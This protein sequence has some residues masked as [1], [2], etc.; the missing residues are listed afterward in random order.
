MRIEGLHIEGFGPF[1]SKTVGPFTGSITV[2]HGA[3]AAGKSTLLAF[4]RMVLFGFPRQ[5]NT[6]YPPLAGG[7]HGGRLRL[8]DDAGN[9]YVVERFR[10]ARGGPVSIIS[11][12][13]APVDEAHLS[14]L[15]GGASS[16][17]FKN[18]FA[19][20]LDELQAE[21]SLRAADVDSQIY[22]AG[23]GA[24]RLP[25][26]IKAIRDKKNAIFR[27]QGRNT[28]ADLIVELEKVGDSLSAAEGNAA[29]YGGFVARLSD[30]GIQL[31]SLNAER[32]RLQ[33]QSGEI[34]RLNQGWGDWVSLVNVES[35]LEA[36]PH[37]DGFPEGGIAR[38]ENNEDQ[39][40]RA[41]QELDETKERSQLVEE[42][43][44]AE[45]ADEILLDRRDVI[46]HIRRGR[47]RFDDSVRDLPERKAE[48]QNLESSLDERLRDISPEWDE[49]R[50]ESFDTSIVTRDHIEQVRQVLAGEVIELRQRTARL[51]QAKGD[52]QELEEAENQARRNL[53]EKEEPTLDAAALEQRRSALR[54]T[55][56]RFEEFA[57]LRLRHSDL[58]DQMESITSQATVSSESP[59]IQSR[60]LPLLLSIVAVALVAISATLG[61][62]SLTIGG[63]AGAVLLIIAL[64][65]YLNANR[66]HQGGNSNENQA[67]L[68]SISKAKEEE[69]DAELKL[70]QVAAVLDLDLPDAVALDNVESGLGASDMALRAWEIVQQRLLNAAEA[71]KQQERRVEN[72]IQAHGVAQKGLEAA[73]AEWQTW[74]TE[75]DLAETLTPETMVEFRGR[76]ETARVALGEVRTMRLRVE[77]IETDIAEYLELVVPLADMLGMPINAEDP[78]QLASTADILIERYDVV[79]ESVNR[80]D[81]AR[82]EAEVISQQFRQREQRLAQH[83]DELAKLLITGGTDDPEEFRSRAAQHAERYDMEQKRGDHLVRLQQFSGPGEQFDH[84]KE[85]LAQASPQTLEDSAL[86]LA[87]HLEVNEEGRTAL[88]GE[89][90]EVRIRLSQLTSEEESSALRVK[91]NVLMEDL[92]EQAREWS[93]LTIAEELLLRTRMK[94]E[95][96]RQ[97]EVIQHAQKFFSSITDQRYDRLYSPVGEQVLTVIERTGVSKQPAELSRGT[98]EQLYLSLRFGLIREFGDQMERLP[99]VV[100]EVLVNFDPDRARRAAEAFVELSETN[101]VLVF[102]CHP[103]M[104]TLFSNVAPETQIIQIDSA[105]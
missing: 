71:C 60:G 6:Y 79:R 88:L 18:V 95:E 85:E 37:F 40:A 25:H 55:R 42:S 22:S 64:F 1:A 86:E 44:Q 53:E 3:N 8:V 68:N 43:A 45:F 23:M 41:K 10:G 33:R 90:G 12:A 102:T 82:K 24:A 72:A 49:D 105:E 84:Y 89:Q 39:V 77:A 66:K 2:I 96:E 29:M 46:E 20:S 26:A 93:M 78:R 99:V 16:D 80:R 28:V 63:I 31:D 38:L 92:R 5:S 27:R 58:R 104:V 47:N 61:R 97:P 54:T 34:S 100:D 48:L 36:L 9:R 74:L 17:V 32:V 35:R 81:L 91:K 50:L 87:G 101:Q 57:R 70:R 65:V 56:T 98:R 94:F 51:D 21:N 103:E 59:S 4:I 30:I 73:R 11:E 15:L 62:Q 67:L 83:Q 14:R 7:R 76:V 69:S 13:G 19:F 75:R 52:L